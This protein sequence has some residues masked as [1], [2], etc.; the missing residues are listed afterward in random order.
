MLS[1]DTDLSGTPVL[2]HGVFMFLYGIQIL[3]IML[4]IARDEV[5]EVWTAGRY[6]LA[7]DLYCLEM[8][9][10]RHFVGFRLALHGIFFN[11]FALIGILYKS[12][13]GCNCEVYD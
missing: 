12:N 9:E 6:S 10:L 2:H 8:I 7:H 3:Q 4:I 13:L 1:L 5:V 11:F